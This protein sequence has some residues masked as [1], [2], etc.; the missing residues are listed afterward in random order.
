[1]E[2]YEKLYKKALEAVKELQSANP[3]DEGIQNWVEDSFP[4]LKESEDERIRKAIIDFFGE[5]GRKEYILN[6]F[7]VDD[8]VAW[9]EKQSKENMIEALR[10][11]YEKGKS[12]VLQEQRKE[13]TSEDLL[14][15]NEIMGILQEYNRDDLIDWLEK[16]GE[17]KPFDY[18]N[19]NIRQKDFAPKDEPKF[20]DTLEDKGVD[21][22][23]SATHYLLY[24]HRSPLNEIMH[25]VDLKSE[26]QYHKDI[27]HAYKAGFE[28]GLK[29]QKGE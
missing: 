4:Q 26:M 1:M 18:E 2:D 5:P 14:N 3:S 17:Q 12:D 9:L 7:N 19:A 8:I 10:L 29:A 27:E 16:Q 24:E 13:W 20:V 23:S 11:E 6:G 25:Q 28:L 21:L 15:H 22:D